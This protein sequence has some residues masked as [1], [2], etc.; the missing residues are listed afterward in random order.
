MLYIFPIVEGHGD[1]RALPVL[2]RH[3]LG[4]KF[5]FYQC[6]VLHPYRLPKGKMKQ[7]DEWAGVI[8][9]ACERLK[10]RTT[11]QEDAA[12]ILVVCDADDDCPVDLKNL[13]DGFVDIHDVNISFEFVAPQPEYETWLLAS[14]ASFVGHPDCIDNA[15]HIPDLLGI[16]NAK[17][18]FEQYILKPGRFYSETVDQA[19][20]SSLINFGLSPESNCRSLR[21]FIDIFQRIVNPQ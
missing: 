6:E 15:P 9:L 1:E 16:R 21:R 3:L 7:A 20:F 19:K 4:T 5:G 13:V 8:G 11:D 18:Y 2:I 17:G 14:A 12:L 10:E